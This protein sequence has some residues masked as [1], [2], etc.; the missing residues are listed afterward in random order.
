VSIRPRRGSGPRSTCSTRT[1][2]G[3]RGSRPAAGA[4]SPYVRAR[5]SRVIRLPPKTIRPPPF[6]TKAA[7]SR[8]GGPSSSPTFARITTRKAPRSRV[9]SSSGGT[10]VS[11]NGVWIRTSPRP[12]GSRAARRKY[13]SPI[14]AVGLGS[15][16]TASTPIRSRTGT[17]KCRTSSPGSASASSAIRPVSSSPAVSGV[18]SK[19]TE[20]LAPGATGTV[21]CPTRSFPTYTETRA[22][23]EPSPSPRTVAVSARGCP[24]TAVRRPGTTSTSV[25]FGDRS[26][27]RSPTRTRTPSG[28]APPSA[29]TARRCR[30]DRRRTSRFCSDAA[31]SSSP[32][33]STAARSVSSP[34]P[35]S[36][37]RMR[38]RSSP[39][40]PTSVAGSSSVGVSTAARSPVSRE[41]T[42]RRAA[43]WARRKR[44]TFSSRYPMLR[45]V[46]STTTSA[47]L[48]PEVDRSARTGRAAA[49]ASSASRRA[50]AARIRT[51]RSRFRRIVRASI[52]R[53]NMSD[54]NHT[55][56]ERR[57]C[58]RWTT[59]GR[60]TAPRPISMSG[61]RNWTI[62]D[63]PAFMRLRRNEARSSS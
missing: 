6:R 26:R 62:P 30:S 24:R 28:R 29:P 33:L 12:V 49:S 36:A 43:S 37:V 39:R 52:F 41:S 22:A 34:C 18:T 42:A 48:P 20:A 11:R 38:W 1:P 45:L 35:T 60:A 46:S 56:R 51:S 31:A 53:R 9:P 14:H 10:T 58:M 8:A 47:V 61:L 7:R 4:S 44:V 27:P 57:R 54:G 19:I 5:A 50:R 59:T 55:S 15:P 13:V 32:A 63:Q 23:A 21:R 2:R 40:S 16:S 25:R 17:A 3:R